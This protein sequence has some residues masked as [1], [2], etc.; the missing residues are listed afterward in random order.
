MN[1]NKLKKECLFNLIFCYITIF[2]CNYLIKS[3]GLEQNPKELHGVF[4]SLVSLIK[5]IKIDLSQY[6]FFDNNLTYFLG[7]I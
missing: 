6:L 2:F 7:K 4:V 3:R 1:S 5:V